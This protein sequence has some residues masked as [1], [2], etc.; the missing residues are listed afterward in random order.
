MNNPNLAQ[1]ENALTALGPIADE[2]VLVGGCATGLLLD[3]ATPAQVRPTRDVDVLVE[4]LS[5]SDY[6]LLSE[7]LRS[8]GFTEDSHDP[9]VICRWHHRH[10]ALD[11]MPTEKILG[12]GNRWYPLAFASASLCKLPSGRRLKLITPA[13]FLATKLEAFKSRGNGDFQSSHDIEDIITLIDGCSRLPINVAESQ[14]ELKAYL[15][16]HLSQLL[17]Q[18]RF[19]E[20][21]PG[22]LPP[23]NASQARAKFIVQQLT[24]MSE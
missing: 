5:L 3:E 10:I 24:A 8:R 2:L 21:L 14:P 9:P 13:C 7:R 19:I 18:R 12:F 6:Y 17:S 11:V 16:D 22:H 23:D 1:L 20:A 4:A 15:T